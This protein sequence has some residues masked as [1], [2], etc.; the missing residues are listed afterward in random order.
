MELLARL[1]REHGTAILL[2]THNFGIIRGVADRVA[3]ML[4]GEMVEQGPEEQ[5]LTAPAHPYTT[6]LISCVPAL[7]R[8]QRRLP[9]FVSES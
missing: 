3:V 7:G 4:R 6:G 1:K 8:R 5:V 9:V 2:I